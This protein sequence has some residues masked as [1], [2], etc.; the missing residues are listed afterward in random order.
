M[1]GR[2]TLEGPAVEALA[3]TTIAA[4]GSRA[5]RILLEQARLLYAAAHDAERH[6][7]DE[8]A[9]RLR[10]RA[11]DHTDA[12]SLV[13]GWQSEVRR[14]FELVPT[15][16]AFEDQRL[17][18]VDRATAMTFPPATH[19]APASAWNASLA[20]LLQPDPLESHLFPSA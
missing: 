12:S 4:H 2:P 3:L 16:Q 20:A 13:F 6:G 15:L 7:A 5:P 11:R 18:P 8:E 19:S 10:T 1:S 9:A 17:G 14:T